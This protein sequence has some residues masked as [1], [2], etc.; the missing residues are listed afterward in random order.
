VVEFEK[1]KEEV[2][3]EFKVHKR[4]DKFREEFADIFE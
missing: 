2:S 3:A 1:K 4:Y